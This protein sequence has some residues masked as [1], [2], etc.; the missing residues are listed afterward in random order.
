MKRYFIYIIAIMFAS[1]LASADTSV[2]YTY[3]ALNRLTK[4]KYSNGVTVTYT[5]DALGNRTKKVV[6][7]SAVSTRGDVDGSGQV[8]IDD[9]AVLVD[10]L[11]SGN[12]NGV[13]LSNADCS[14]DGGV[15][16]NDVSSLIDYFLRGYW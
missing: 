7:A 10:Y 11:M 8:D 2:N 1:M 9:L 3:D 15:D 5:Y 16:I 6:T 4:V 14:Q 12:S 13:N